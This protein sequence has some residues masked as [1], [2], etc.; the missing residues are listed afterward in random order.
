[1]RQEFKLSP[2]LLCLNHLN[3]L[4]QVHQIEEGGADM[5]H[6]DILDGHFSPS[7][8]LGF[9][10]IKQLRKEVTIP[11]DVH[12]M[13]QDNPYFFDEICGIGFE[14]ITF[15]LESVGHPDDLISTLRRRMPK[16]KVGVA[17]K[18]S[19][20]LTSVEYLLETCDKVLLMAIEPGYASYDVKPL[21]YIDRKILDLYNMVKE[22]G[23]DVEIE[24][25]GRVSLEVMQKWK[26]VITT[27]VCGSASLQRDNL[28]QSLKD[29]RYELH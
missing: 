11:F 25:D 22:R 18:P 15:Q 23:L 16:A 6:V 28:V 27:F 1:M 29:I 17:L 7:M 8:P 5:L 3:V 4:Q 26:G 12:V 19:T 9:E 21:P 20:P 13:V 14:E 10:M 24:L 2:S